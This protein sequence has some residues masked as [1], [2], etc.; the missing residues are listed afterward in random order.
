M[1]EN[2]ESLLVEK[3]YYQTVLQN[4]IMQFQK[5]YNLQ[6]KKVT[7][8]P[9]KG[10]PTKEDQNN[11]PSSSQPK[12]EYVAKYV[13]EK[14]KEKE[15][16]HKKVPEIRKETIIKDVE[17]TSSSF[18]FESEMAK[19]KIFIPFNELIK[20]SE[21]RNQIINMLNMEE[22]FDTLNIQDDHPSILFGPHVEESS[23]VDEVPP[24]Y[25]SLKIHDMNLHNVMLD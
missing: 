2:Y 13:V 15:E 6:K 16:P 10:N 11:I 8:N 18:N 14:G 3:E 19:I 9:S 20:N 12:E 23:D 17:K 24:L 22:T 25:V 4:P 5:Q 21:Y 7:A 1:K